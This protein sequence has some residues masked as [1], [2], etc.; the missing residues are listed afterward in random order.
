MKYSTVYKVK[1]MKINSLIKVNIPISFN[2]YAIFLYT[3]SQELTIMAKRILGKKRTS[4]GSSLILRTN[5]CK[6]KEHAN[7][8]YP[9]DGCAYIHYH[10]NNVKSIMTGKLKSWL[11][12]IPG[13]LYGIL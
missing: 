4:R 2:Q 9:A 12:Q 13:F 8:L 6:R 1:V 10:Y 5:S 11:I 7:K 3:S